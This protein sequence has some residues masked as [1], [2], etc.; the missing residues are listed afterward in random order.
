LPGDR[1]I[2]G[3]NADG[4][5][6]LLAALFDVSF[7]LNSYPDV[8]AAGIDPMR[9]YLDFGWKEGRDP[10]PSFR[11]IAYLAANPEV[12]KAGICPLVDYVTSGIV[13]ER[14]LDPATSVQSPRQQIAPAFDSKYY[15]KTYSDVATAGVDPLDHYL[16]QGWREGRNPSPAFDTTYYLES[17][18][19]VRE[20]GICPLIHYVNRGAAEGRL[21]RRPNNPAREAL[22]S[23]LPKSER[24]KPWL[25]PL[26]SPPLDNRA[27][28]DALASVVDSRTRGIV[29]TISHDDFS[30]I[31]GVQNCVRDEERELRAKGW[32]Y[33]HLCPAQ[34]LP[35]LADRMAA[36]KF[37][38]GVRVNGRQIGVASFRALLKEAQFATFKSLPR[39]LVLHHLMGFCPELLL[40]FV[41]QFAPDKTIAWVHDLFTLCP[42]WTMLRNNVE[43]CGGPKL[44]SV[45]CGIC[46]YGGAERKTHL[47]RLEKVFDALKPD[48]LFPSEVI[49]EFWV[50]R[51]PL[52]HTAAKVAPHGTLTMGAAVPTRRKDQL[53]LRVGFTGLPVYHKGWYVFEELAL[54]HHQDSRYSFFHFGV[55]QRDVARNITFVPVAVDATSRH[56]MIDALIANEIDVVV[57][58]SLWYETFSFVAYEAVAAGAFVLAPK[59]AGNVVPAVSQ[60]GVEQGMGL[61]SADQLF[62]LFATGEVFDLVTSRRYGDFDIRAGT[63]DHLEGLS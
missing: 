14:P 24:V 19:D 3:P 33:L 21:P 8:R 40:Q 51:S 16:A 11:T 1:S 45:A 35:V 29:V 9:H 37:F 38:V 18:I 28:R 5:Y 50:A 60:P 42:S 34:P 48:M 10:S 58:W 7:Y 44:D 31:G 53:Q 30:T 39:V 26:A 46:V 57:I 61:E 25:R 54:R 27:V 2:E 17:N 4:T 22:K 6:T 52:K 15:L 49:K 59:E 47:A 36:E 12:E 63:I 20:S 23:A 13:L 43:F 41:Q 56:A 32:A 55:N 62:E